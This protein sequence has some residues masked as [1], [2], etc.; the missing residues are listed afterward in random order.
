VRLDR[1]AEFTRGGIA[2][3]DRVGM[4]RPELCVRDCSQYESDGEANHAID[5]TLSAGKD[6]GLTRPFAAS[7]RERALQSICGLLVDHPHRWALD[8]DTSKR[9]PAV[10]ETLISSTQTPRQ[11]RNPLAEIQ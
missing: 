2:R 3:H 5:L 7:F 4:N 6:C 11:R 8:P 1:D 10:M 9:A